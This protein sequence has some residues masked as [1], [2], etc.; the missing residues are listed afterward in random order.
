LIASR[1]PRFADD[2]VTP[3][4]PTVAR[5]LRRCH[6]GTPLPFAITSAAL[7]TTLATNSLDHLHPRRVAR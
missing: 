2:G 6:S 5:A 4:T 1:K 3:S 7:T